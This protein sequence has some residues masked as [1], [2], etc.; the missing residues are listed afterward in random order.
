MLETIGCSAGCPGSRGRCVNAKSDQR[1]RGNRKRP[2][3]SGPQRQAFKRALVPKKLGVTG[4]PRHHPANRKVGQAQHRNRD[5]PSRLRRCRLAPGIFSRMRPSP[6][7]KDGFYLGLDV[8]HVQILDCERVAG[9]A[10]QEQAAAGDRQDQVRLEAVG[11]DDLRQLPGRLA[12]PLPAEVLALVVRRCLAVESARGA[13]R[14]NFRAAAGWPGACNVPLGYSA[15]KW[16]GAGR[17][18]TCRRARRRA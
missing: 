17:V 2:S 12:G 1:A 9:R 3:G 8:H 10:G 6:G 13:V 7:D 14:G 18:R 15:L 5:K 16:C 4:S 11:G